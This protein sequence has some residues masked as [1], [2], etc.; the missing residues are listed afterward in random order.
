[1]SL[2]R[3][4]LIA[5]IGYVVI[6]MLRVFTNI[7]RTGDHDTSTDGG[8]GD[9]SVRPPDDFLR[10]DIKDAEFEDLN[11]PEDTPQPPKSS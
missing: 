1:M 11:P 5:L 3:L 2:M 4:L 9:Q 10:N 7:K 8:E 6:R